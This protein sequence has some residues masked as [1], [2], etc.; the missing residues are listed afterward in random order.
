[1]KSQGNPFLRTASFVSAI[2]L[3]V[4]SAHAASLFWDGNDTTA[5]ADGGVGTW[6]VT[7]TNW[8]ALA[9]SGANSA[10][11]NANNDTAV[12]AGTAGTVSLGAPITVGGL[13]FDTAGYLVQTNT[14]TFGVSGNIVTNADA[15]INSA[16]AATTGLTITKTGSGIL[17]LGGNNTYA[18][19]TIIS[20]GTLKAS[21]ITALSANSDYSVGAGAFLDLGGF[22]NTIKSLS[23]ATGTVTNSNG[24]ATLKI[25]TL[26]STAQLFTGSLGLQVSGSQGIDLT[27]SANTYSGG[28]ILGFATGVNTRIL[29]GAN[30]LGAGTPG[31]LTSGR[32]GT[33][34]LTLG[35]STTDRAQIMFNGTGTINNAIVVNSSLGNTDAAGAFR[36]DSSGSVI[37]GAINANLAAANFRN[38]GNGTGG[39]NVTGAISGNSGLM[40]LA[41]NGTG[42][43]NV[44]LSNTGTANSY[45][46]DTTISSLKETLTLGAS[47]QIS[48]GAGKGNLI[49][50]GGNFKMNGFSETINGLSGTGIV[51]GVSGTSTLT[52]GDNDATGAANTF[53]GVIKNTA[54]TLALTKIG[55]GTL[56][57]SGNNTYGGATTISFGTLKAGSITGLS[58]SSATSVAAGATLD[59][60]GFNNTIKS[61]STSGGTITNS[62]G[63]GTLKIADAMSSTLNAHL[64]TGSLGLQLYGGSTAN[65][66]LSNTANTYSGGTIFGNGSGTTFTRILLSGTVGAGSPGAVTSGIFGTGVITMGSA[67]TDR[68]Q[69]YF[70]GA[71]TI[72]N[73]FVVNSAQG[74]GSNELG[75]FRSESTGIVLAG[76]INANL[77]DVTFNAINGTGRAINVTGAIS[78]DSGLTVTAA[79]LG[80]LTVTLTNAGTANSYAGNT[81]ISGNGNATLTLGRANQIS[82][83]AGK[84]NLIVTA[85]AFNMGGFSETINGLSGAGTVDGI[86]G[87]PTLTVGDNDATGADNT[88]SGVI[89]N[90]AGTLALTKIGSGTLTLS[91][92][93]TYSGATTVTTGTL[94]LNGS[95]HASSAVAIA[96]A[97]T[98][99]GSGTVNGNATLTGNGIIN[100]ASGTLAGT[101]GVTGG[102]WN[103]AGAV[104]GLVTSSS[105]AFNIGNGANLTANGGLDV[106]G[107]T[108]AAGNAAS[109]ITGS[110][111]Y[112]SASNSTFAGVIA[113]ASKTLTMNNAAAKLIL[114]GANT[115]TGATNVTAGVLAVNGSLGNTTT[116]IGT[117]ATLQGSG[118]I[119]GSV[120]VNGGGTLATGNSIE[121]LATGALS[122]LANST[123]AYEI[124]NEVAAGAAGDLTAVT[125][126]LTLDLA[127]AAILT[128]TE[129]GSD[130]WTLGEKLTLIS[131]SGSWNGG[132]FNYGGNTLA[133]DS[134]F[135]FS[136]STWSFNYND[137]LAGD[138]FT[139]DLTSGS[140]VT[141]TVIPEPNV[142]ALIG[143]FGVLLILRRRR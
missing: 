100:K 137:N 25:T 130:S 80:G 74:N 58:A 127:N 23:T 18:A 38:G 81:T 24:N 84:G 29:L 59:L 10:W 14:L 52:V 47:N 44:T 75:A 79:G 61:L 42:T 62:T 4:I 115:Y 21:S 9:S 35:A 111:N 49:V 30:T 122:L 16:I 54:G 11:T 40:L 94:Q 64:F 121:S 113:G 55:T 110:L 20:A 114:T 70:A 57:L 102:N 98:L 87:T 123:F 128:L 34:A 83:G 91:G 43:L 116:T 78:G 48:N 71:T 131:Y 1:M 82:N 132:L 85:G 140:F 105:G 12:F 28:T 119:A 46:G 56:T 51:D 60:G 103:G 13:Q 112:T 109:T 124:N 108:I 66:I 67:A 41:G 73:A 89:K 68:S 33:G 26:S 101:L 22:N 72:N 3:S 142:A 5:N 86:S 92:T 97:G 141:M 77:A 107:G 134:S 136:G 36:V 63:N 88:F 7:A 76:A 17:T 8:D 96:T 53:S 45:A 106:T 2:C 37:N 135:T 6:D 65:T 104:T 69:F 19:A 50:T 15:T 126:N 117:G 27:N 125:G 90:T 39:I 143:G 118:S 129:L 31:S 99:T 138:N 95:T 120:T 139:S 93:N 32:F 133:D